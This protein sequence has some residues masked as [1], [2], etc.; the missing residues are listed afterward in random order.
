M[1]TK[2]NVEKSLVA[3]GFEETEEG[4]VLN[5]AGRPKTKWVPVDDGFHRFEREDGAWAQYPFSVNEKFARVSGLAY[6]THP[7]CFDEVYPFEHVGN[8]YAVAVAQRREAE[9]KASARKR[10]A[11][12]PGEAP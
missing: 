2:K 4:F 3:Y 11:S 9:E 1:T 7:E 6:D 12:A 8:I 10:Q 5:K